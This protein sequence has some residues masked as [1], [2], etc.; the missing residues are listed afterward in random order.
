M[1]LGIETFKCEFGETHD[2][3]SV[4]DGCVEGGESAFEV[5]ILVD[6][7]FLLNECNTHLIPFGAGELDSPDLHARVTHMTSSSITAALI[8]EVFVNDPDGLRLS[9]RLRD[10]REGGAELAILPELP[11]DP[12]IPKRREADPND[13]EGPNGQRQQAMAVAAARSGVAVLGGAII[14]DPATGKRH[15]TALL[16]KKDGSLVAAYR[17]LHLP[18]EEN[19]WEAAHYEPGVDPPQVISGFEIP[20]GIQICSDS[21]RT[22]GCHLL[23][24]Q[25]AGVIFVPRA[26]PET[27]WNRWR[28]VLRANAVTSAAW[29]VTVNRPPEGDPSPIGGPSAVISPT[30]EMVGES[31]HGVLIA[32]LDQKA[33]DQARKAY[34]GY[35]DHQP[36]VHG[37]GWSA[38]GA[39]R[40]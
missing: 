1:I 40:G 22:S 20:L 2:I 5:D 32:T 33:V 4:G 30:G 39:Q 6:G 36:E 28:L 14:R 21:N 25:G 31:T 23:A 7:G 10:A 13:A 24:A 29:V 11:M 18:F 38:L 12:W 8:T 34:P 17:K 3:G 37:K 19:F 15:N 35:L 16:Y 27:S 9:G 26:T